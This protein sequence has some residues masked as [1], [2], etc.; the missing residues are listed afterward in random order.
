[1]LYLT[2]AQYRALDFGLNVSSGPYTLTDAQLAAILTRATS[3][4]NDHCMWPVLPKPHTFFGDSVVGETHTWSVDPYRDRQTRVWPKHRPVLTITQMR[5]YATPTQYLAFDPAELYYE[6]SEGWIEPASANLTSFGLFG[7]SVLPQVGLTQP[8][9]KLDYTYGEVFDFTERVY[10]TATTNLWRGTI[11]WW[12]A[13]PVVKVNGVVRSGNMTIDLDEGT[14]LFTVSSLPGATDKVEIIGAT[15]ISPDIPLATGIIATDRI[16]NRAFLASGIPVGIRSFKVAEVAVDRGFQRAGAA[17]AESTLPPE[18]E[19][20]L[21][22]F[23]YYP[24]GF[25]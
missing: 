10:M 4:V 24:L 2:P 25:L 23:V 6:P 22:P 11:G 16:S 14:V 7:S 1:M 12:N 8:H 20:K 21:A 13:T 18:A 17:V 5:I 3:D 9:A 15:K 19:E